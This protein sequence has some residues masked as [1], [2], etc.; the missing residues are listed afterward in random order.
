[1]TYAPLLFTIAAIGIV[2]LVLYLGWKVL[3][4]EDRI[5]RGEP[6][7]DYGSRM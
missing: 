2:A 3:S 4:R 7:S 5:S 6:D 1:M